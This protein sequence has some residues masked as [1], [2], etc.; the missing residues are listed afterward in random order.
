[1]NLVQDE[2][3]KSL[4]HRWFKKWSW[5]SG[6]LSRKY[7]K[8]TGDINVKNDILKVVKENP[9]E[10]HYNHSI[11]KDFLPMTQNPGAVIYLTT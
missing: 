2:G 8:W 5:T 4:E 11:G 9:G 3:D 1:M 10:F 7:S 6:Q